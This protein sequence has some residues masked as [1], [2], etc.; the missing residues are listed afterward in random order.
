MSFLRVLLEIVLKPRLIPHLKNDR[1]PISFSLMISDANID[2]LLIE[3]E[4][5]LV[6]RTV[7]VIK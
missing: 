4:A 3:L 7:L 5:I 6:F 2:S 1:L